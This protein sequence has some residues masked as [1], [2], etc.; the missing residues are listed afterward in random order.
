[1]EQK[2]VAVTDPKCLYSGC[3][4]PAVRVVLIVDGVAK[5]GKCE[6][7]YQ[8]DR[9]E[10]WGSAVREFGGNVVSITRGKR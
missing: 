9:A 8:R 1:V 10:P 5:S 3:G 6:A 2:E 7:H 4:Q